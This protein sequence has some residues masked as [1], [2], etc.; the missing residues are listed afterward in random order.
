MTNPI[1]TPRPTLADRWRTLRDRLERSGVED[2]STQAR[3]QAIAE[4][5]GRAGDSR[6]L[7]PASPFAGRDRMSARRQPCRDLAT[8]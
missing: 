3:T 4:L 2:A 1:N 6:R 5:T 7:D 8:R